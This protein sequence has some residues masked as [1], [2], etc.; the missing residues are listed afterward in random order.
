MSRNIRR[1]DRIEFQKGAS[2][3][4]KPVGSDETV[5]EVEFEGAPALLIVGESDD[6]FEGGRFGVLVPLDLTVTVRRCLAAAL[7][8]RHAAE[9]NGV[10]TLSR[11]EFRVD[12]RTMR[13]DFDPETDLPCDFV[14]TETDLSRLYVDLYDQFLPAFGFRFRTAGRGFDAYAGPSFL[15]NLREIGGSPE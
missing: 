13:F 6:D 7:A 4:P 15:D 10:A 3:K 8:A 5:F 2:M 14:E 1:L 9:V 11:T 12:A